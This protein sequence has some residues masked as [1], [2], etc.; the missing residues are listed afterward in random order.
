MYMF[1]EYCAYYIRISSEVVFVF[2]RTALFSCMTPWAQPAGTMRP[3]RVM[4][5]SSL[6]LLLVVVVVVVVVVVLSLL[7]TV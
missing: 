2:S 7:F 3:L 1:I 4:Q 6:L 5:K